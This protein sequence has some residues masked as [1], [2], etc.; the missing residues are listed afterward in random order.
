MIAL[1]RVRDVIVYVIRHELSCKGNKCT[2]LGMVLWGANVHVIPRKLSSNG[3]KCTG[4]GL[5]LPTSGNV[6]VLV[7]LNW[8]S[9][10]PA[11]TY[12][13]A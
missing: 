6:D 3:N 2:G 5:M 1:P 12:L 8:M 9:C 11:W 10:F 7:Q 4:V 13:Y